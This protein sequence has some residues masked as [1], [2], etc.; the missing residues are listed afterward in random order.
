[1]KTG[2]GIDRSYLFMAKLKFVK[3]DQLIRYSVQEL[4]LP[5]RFSKA[6]ATLKSRTGGGGGG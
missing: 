5:Y 2:P 1:V 6:R 3:I 4:D